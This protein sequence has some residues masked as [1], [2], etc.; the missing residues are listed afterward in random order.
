MH[1]DK[2]ARLLNG[3]KL[4]DKVNTKVLLDKLNMLSVNQ[5]N[6]QIKITE[7]WKNSQDIDYPLKFIPSIKLR[8]DKYNNMIEF[9]KS[10]LVKSSFLS[11]ASK[12]W[13]KTPIE[14]KECNTLWSAKKAIKTFVKQLPI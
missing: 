8:P 4:I 9:G 12:A 7:A 11:D 13:N 3:K 5:I 10:D 6:A 1:V 2:L 14:I